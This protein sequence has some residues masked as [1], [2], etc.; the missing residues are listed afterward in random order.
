MSP[1]G[2][3]LCKEEE[4]IKC[5]CTWLGE[6]PAHVVGT[7]PGLGAGSLRVWERAW[8]GWPALCTLFLVC[9]DMCTS[10]DK[11]NRKTLSCE[12][13]ARGPWPGPLSPPVARVFD[14]PGERLFP[15]SSE[16]FLLFPSGPRL[17]NRFKFFEHVE[18]PDVPSRDPQAHPRGRKLALSQSRATSVLAPAL[19]EADTQCMSPGIF[20]FKQDKS[21]RALGVGLRKGRLEFDPVSAH[22]QGWL[23][24]PP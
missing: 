18:D 9:S 2:A 4:F 17:Y 7:R 11:T 12:G 22:A 16:R 6:V 1:H 19:W 24:I 5:D 8:K 23:W 13:G 21:Q 14:L 20:Q 10:K 3:G 15:S